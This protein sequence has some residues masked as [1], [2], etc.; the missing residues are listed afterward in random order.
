MLKHLTLRNF[1]AFR[2]VE[3][4]FSA[5][6]IFVGPNNSGKSSVLSAINLLAQTIAANESDAPLLLRG[7]Y[8]D[9]GTYIDVVHGNIPRTPISIDFSTGEFEY[10]IEFK[11]RSQRR[12]I[13]V[14][15]YEILKDDKSIYSYQAR[16]D[17]YE[18]RYRGRRFEQHLGS[19]AKRRPDFAGLLVRE[20][21]LSGIRF[22]QT[23]KREL[24]EILDKTKLKTL[25]EVERMIGRANAEL[26][27][28]FGQ[29][30]SLSPFRETPQRTFLFSGESPQEVGRTGEKAVD[31]LVSDN[32]ARGKTKR[33]IVDEISNFFTNTGMARAIEVKA[34][35]SRHYEL[36]VI[37]ND[38]RSHNICDVGFG[39]SQ[40][41]PVIVGGFN[42]F[43]FPFP[44]FYG[45][46]GPI[47]VV[48]EPEIHLHPDAQAELGTF[49]VN[50]AKQNG[51]LF[52]ETHSDNLI[53]RVQ[54]HVAE[55]EIDASCIR[56]FFVQDLD[57][58]KR[59]TDI[60]LNEEGVFTKP[61]PGGFFP[62]R[63]QESFKL[64]RAAATRTKRKK[65]TR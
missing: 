3:L 1:R 28:M 52:I 35:T 34:L 6:N 41:L 14:T 13:E 17:A 64:A 33:G 57:G 36:C 15:K 62:Q 18:I 47:F 22:R 58:T 43:H 30:D 27:Y 59:V 46:S 9:L 7:K 44:G 29:F 2:A 11:Y 19:I 50:L 26:R 63:Q 4:N 42:T 56:V 40:V 24:E 16:K 23:R 48:Q 51:Q 49:F 53:L 21:N 38:G 32:F 45:S 55:G 65:N 10:R 54:R 39:C 31:I 61:W 20:R 60:D 8:D 37:G 5:I 25:I 12:E